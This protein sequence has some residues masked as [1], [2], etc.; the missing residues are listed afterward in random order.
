MRLIGLVAV[1]LPLASALP[2]P[3]DS[4]AELSHG[5]L[6]ERSNKPT[7]GVSGYYR[8]NNPPYHTV[9]YTCNRY[10]CHNICGKSSKC[11]SYSVGNG[12]CSLYKSKVAKTCASSSKSPYKFYD[13]ACYCPK[14]PKTTT[15]KSTTRGT[16]RSTTASTTASTTPAQTTTTPVQTTTTPSSTTT[17]PG[18]TTTTTPS[19]PTTTTTTTTTPVITTTSTS[20][21]TTPSTTTPSTTTPSTTTTTSSP[22]I[23]TLVAPA[24]VDTGLGFSFRRYF[25]GVGRTLDP[26]VP[27]NSET[28]R[29]IVT[30]Y[31]VDLPVEQV[32][33]QCVEA[34]SNKEL[35]YL[36]V[37]LH[38]RISS[39]EWQCVQYFGTNDDPSFYSVQDADVLCSFGY[40]AG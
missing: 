21:N 9:S 40:T 38:F 5:T 28:G 1:L 8:Q 30:T 2:S 24:E 22:P 10:E 26:N 12:K 19:V 17:T 4:A 32:A 6:E 7:C 14:P 39:R 25:S 37:D 35:P 29:P 20:T 34:A 18:A 13:K 36:T 31:P 23:C 27:A 11:Q 15:T 33:Q 3:L 16:T